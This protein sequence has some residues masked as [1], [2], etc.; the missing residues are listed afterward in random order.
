MTHKIEF[1]LEAFTLDLLEFYAVDFFSKRQE[2]E[3]FSIRLGILK[4]SVS[5]L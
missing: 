3:A 4:L 2:A 1:A 5:L